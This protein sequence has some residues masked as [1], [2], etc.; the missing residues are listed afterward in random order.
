M[1]REFNHIDDSMQ[2]RPSQ[3]T[4][5]NEIKPRYYGRL[6]NISQDSDMLNNPNLVRLEAANWKLDKRFSSHILQL[7]CSSFHS[8]SLQR[9]LQ[10]TEIDN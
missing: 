2:Y 7:F 3:R 5:N 9:T 4:D 1:N 8:S 6:A 10:Y